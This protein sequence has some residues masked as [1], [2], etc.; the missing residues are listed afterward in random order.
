[1]KHISLKQLLESSIQEGPAEEQEVRDILKQD[2][3]SFVSKLGDNINDPKFRQ[4]IKVAASDNPIHTTDMAPAVAELK[5]T[6]NEIDVD[7]NY[8]RNPFPS[9]LRHFLY[10]FDYEG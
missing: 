8:F 5:P 3:E 1:M 7:I 10:Y 6:Q 2:Y 9:Y 4:A